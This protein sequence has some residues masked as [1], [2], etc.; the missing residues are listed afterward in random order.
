MKDMGLTQGTIV[1]ASKENRDQ[2]LK[3]TPQMKIFDELGIERIC[4]RRHFLAQVD[5]LESQTI[6]RDAR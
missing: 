6:V 5:I 3:D 1:T 2:L 4:C